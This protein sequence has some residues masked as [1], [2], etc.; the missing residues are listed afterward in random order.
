[1]KIRLDHCLPRRLKRA[2]LP[3]I[4]STAAEMGWERLRNGKLLA[5]AAS[6]FDVFLTIDK[7]LK[8]EQNLATLPISVVVI[9]APSNRMEDILPFVPVVIDGLK[10]IQ[11]KT[12]I[13]VF[14]PAP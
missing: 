6:Q 4:A 3:H 7:N 9:M 5:A 10:S 8:H 14:L 1:V 12:L 13:E 11:P 2:I